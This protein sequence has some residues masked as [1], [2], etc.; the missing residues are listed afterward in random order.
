MSLRASP[1]CRRPV[2]GPPPPTAV[3]GGRKVANAHKIASPQGDLLL[4]AP[5]DLDLTETIGLPPIGMEKKKGEWKNN[6]RASQVRIR[7]V[8]QVWGIGSLVHMYERAS[9]V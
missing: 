2:T 7:P 1:E 4:C 8:G 3:H 5:D 9:H 6:E